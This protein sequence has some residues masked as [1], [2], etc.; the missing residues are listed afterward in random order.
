MS[1]TEAIQLSP[2][3]QDSLVQRLEEELH[4]YAQVEILSG[5]TPDL[6]PKWANL[7]NAEPSRFIQDQSSI[8][9]DA[10]VN[11]R[12]NQIFIP[13]APASNVHPLLFPNRILGGRRGT[14]KMLKECLA[15]LKEHGYDDLLRKYP[16]NEVGNPRIFQHQRFRYTFRWFKHIYF[17]GLLDRILRPSLAPDFIGLDIGTSYGIFP[18]LV[19]QEWPGSRHVLVDFPEQLLLAYYFLSTTFPDAKIAGFSE[20]TK[21]GS[22]TRSFIEKYDF[23]L[24]PISHYE[25]MEPGSVDLVSNFASFGEMDRKWFDNYLKADP[26]LSAKYF[27][28]A[29]RVQS[30]PEYDT[31]LTIQDYPVWDREKTLHF[32]IS[33]AF[34]G[35]YRYDRRFIVLNERHAYPAYFEYIGRI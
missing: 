13:D 31:D 22:I 1:A 2:T 17:I 14:V 24:V 10:L 18:S 8:N 30:Y 23:T 3:G 29:N 5:G 26:F 9:V 11:F 33:P 25:K 21:Q 32:G 19:K 7:T 12:R 4:S 27:F 16:C 20:V 34:C 35:Y 15:V 6:I 28:T